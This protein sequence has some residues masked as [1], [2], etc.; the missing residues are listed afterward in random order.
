SCAA[1]FAG[2]RAARCASAFFAAFASASPSRGESAVDLCPPPTPACVS[3]SSFPYLRTSFIVLE[4]AA[5]CDHPVTPMTPPHFS[6]AVYTCRS[7]REILLSAW[8]A[9]PFAG[10]LTTNLP[11]LR[12]EGRG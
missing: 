12:A 3:R 5:V 7:R 4:D 1:C 8:P 2:S 9:L 11:P 6:T 10:P